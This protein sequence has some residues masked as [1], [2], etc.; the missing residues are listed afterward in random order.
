MSHLTSSLCFCGAATSAGDRRSASL[1]RAC[2]EA[3]LS[4]QMGG[5]A[6]ALVLYFN[7]PMPRH[8]PN[9]RRGAYAVTNVSVC[10]RACLSSED[11][12]DAL[13]HGFQK[14][15]LELSPDIRLIH[16]QLKLVEDLAACPGLKGAVALFHSD[17]ALGSL[18]EDVDAIAGHIGPSNPGLAPAAA[19][20]AQGCVSITQGCTLC[21][22]CEWACPTG[23]IHLGEE[24]QTL[25]IRDNQCTGCGLCASACPERVLAIQPLAPVRRRA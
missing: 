20:E 12:L 16:H 5:G 19:P 24:G 6:Q 15:F 11:V 10:T 1:E 7:V 4:S 22:Q 2:L 21:G 18:L 17:S 23:A 13:A 9:L 3:R 8:P 25:E 14:V